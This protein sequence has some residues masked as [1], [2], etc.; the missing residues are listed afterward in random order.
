MKNESEEKKKPVLH[1]NDEKE[2]SAVDFFTRAAAEKKR[3]IEMGI[4]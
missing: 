4:F 2:I 3:Q 1:E